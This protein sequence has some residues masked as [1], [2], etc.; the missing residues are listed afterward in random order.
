LN[1]IFIDIV[2]YRINVKN[3][4]LKLTTSKFF[5]YF[6][7]KLEN[8]FCRDTFCRLDYPCWTFKRYTVN[9]KMNMVAV[10]TYL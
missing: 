4:C 8:L 6:W 5:L 2:S 3:F 7:V 10:C 9:Q 1:C